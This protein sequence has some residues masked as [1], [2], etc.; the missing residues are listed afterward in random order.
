MAIV[1]LA[2]VAEVVGETER[3][4]GVTLSLGKGPDHPVLTRRAVPI[5]HLVAVAVV[6]EERVVVRVDRVREDVVLRVAEPHL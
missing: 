4:D 6:V 2:A 3:R 5:T 1:H